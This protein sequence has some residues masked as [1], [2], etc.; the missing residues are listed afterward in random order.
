M[1]ALTQV[2]LNGWSQLVKAFFL[3]KKMSLGED[4]PLYVFQTL[5]QTPILGKDELNG[6][7]Y[8][9]LGGLVSLL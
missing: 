3:W 7:Y 5:L 6:W 9:T 1:L 8:I 2:L 4:V